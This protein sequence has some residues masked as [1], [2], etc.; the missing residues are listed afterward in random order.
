MGLSALPLRPLHTL[1]FVLKG[2]SQL[3][4]HYLMLGSLCIGSFISFEVFGKRYST[5]KNDFIFFF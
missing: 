3:I 4:S 5:Y 1:D 2:L